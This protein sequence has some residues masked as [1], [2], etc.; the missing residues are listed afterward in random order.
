MK[1]V[2][3]LVLALY[4]GLLFA[5][6]I[7][8]GIPASGME[9]LTVNVSVMTDGENDIA[10]VAAGADLSTDNIFRQY[11]VSGQA[12]SVNFISL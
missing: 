4:V 11:K 10:A 8:S 12:V 9:S 1:N 3:F 7:N 2:K 5:G 6:C